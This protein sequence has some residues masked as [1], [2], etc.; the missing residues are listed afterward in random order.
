M[1]N[2]GFHLSIAGGLSKAFNRAEI[3]KITTFQIFTRS[4]RSWNFKPLDEAEINRFH[5]LKTEFEKNFG[6][7]V[8]HMPYLP[9]LASSEEETYKKS[10]ESFLT[11]V[12]R[13]DQLKVDFLDFQKGLASLKSAG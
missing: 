13:C 8:V 1:L 2:F 10:F 4:S 9:N 3:L 7:I 5:H 6:K 12:Q 11:E